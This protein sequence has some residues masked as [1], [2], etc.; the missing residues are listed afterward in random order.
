MYS[1]TK[2]VVSCLF[3]SSASADYMQGIYDLVRRRMP[4][5]A[6]SFQFSLLDTVNDQPDHANQVKDQYVVSSL[7]NGTILIEGNSLSALSY[8]YVNTQVV[9]TCFLLML[10]QTSLSLHR[11]LADVAH[12]DMWWF[13]GNRL[14]VAPEELPAIQ[15]PL[16][17]SSVVPWRYHFNTGIGTLSWW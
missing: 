5:H 4:Q 1:F 8:G 17:G 11:Y 3:A 6:D 13:I 2:L 9:L 14:D 12:V 15:Q 7:Q 10:T 16:T